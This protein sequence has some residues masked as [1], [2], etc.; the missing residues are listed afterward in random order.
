VKLKAAR[1]LY[2]TQSLSEHSQVDCGNVMGTKHFSLG[3]QVTPFKS[4]LDERNNNGLN[5]R[6]PLDNHINETHNYDSNEFIHL[7]FHELHSA[8]AANLR[9]D[10]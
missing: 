2:G 3:N 6:Y 10:L 9:L 1:Y 4:K 5:L 8:E 7:I